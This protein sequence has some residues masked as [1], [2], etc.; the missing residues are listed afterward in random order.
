MEEDGQGLGTP[1]G[2][3]CIAWLAIEGRSTGTVLVPS[4]SYWAGATLYFRTRACL[5]I[6]GH[7]SILHV[8]RPLGLRVRVRVF[9]SHASC[10]RARTVPNC[11]YSY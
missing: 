9:S 4:C 3:P 8:H 7:R 2:G 6:I 10:T 5:A 11:I 1:R